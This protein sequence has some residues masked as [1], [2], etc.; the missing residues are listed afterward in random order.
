MIIECLKELVNSDLDFGVLRKDK[1]KLYLNNFT[2]DQL[3]FILA[4]NGLVAHDIFI[5]FYPGIGFRCLNNETVTGKLPIC[6]I[7]QNRLNKKYQEF[8]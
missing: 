8:L 2:E 5:Y 4:N 7:L 6:N 3:S 1:I